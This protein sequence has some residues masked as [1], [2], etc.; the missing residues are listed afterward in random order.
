MNGRRVVSRICAIY[1]K[2]IFI[3]IVDQSAERVVAL[4][5]RHRTIH[6][7][8]QVGNE[9]SGKWADRRSGMH[10]CLLSPVFA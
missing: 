3:F 4:I 8:E 1:R 10:P 6:S 7:P 5:N 2:D 9:V